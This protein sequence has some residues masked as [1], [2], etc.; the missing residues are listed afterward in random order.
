MNEGL[1]YTLLGRDGSGAR[2]ALSG[3]LTADDVGRLMDLFHDLMEEGANRFEVD[4][5]G[6]DHITSSGIGS[7]VE[8]HRMAEPEG[9]YVRLTGLQSNIRDLLDMTGMLRLLTDSG[10][11]G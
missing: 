6:L 8:V 1:R 10:E 5:A 11:G 2:I 4:I 9:G 3:A 7:L